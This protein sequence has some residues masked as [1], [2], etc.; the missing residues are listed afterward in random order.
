MIDYK[1]LPESI[2]KNRKCKKKDPPTNLLI[3][4]IIPII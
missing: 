4:P 3:F 2:L 1:R